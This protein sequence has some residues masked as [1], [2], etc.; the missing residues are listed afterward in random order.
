M[1]LVCSEISLLD[2]AAE[3]GGGEPMGEHVTELCNLREGVAE[4]RGGK[5]KTWGRGRTGLQEWKT[6][7]LGTRE[8]GASLILQ[9]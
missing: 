1:K 3:D 8:N 4:R 2:G 7:D 5:R 9:G 6:E